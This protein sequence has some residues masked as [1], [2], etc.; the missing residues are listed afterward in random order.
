LEWKNLPVAPTE[1]PRNRGNLSKRVPK[2]NQP[3]VLELV[4]TQASDGNGK[5]CPRGQMKEG[6]STFY[7]QNKAKKNSIDMKKGAQRE[8]E[9]RRRR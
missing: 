9:P 7:K 3:R 4:R 8:G 6:A 5:T 2:K 1:T